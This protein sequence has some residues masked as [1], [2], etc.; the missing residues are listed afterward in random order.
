MG[1]ALLSL[2]SLVAC[3]FCLSTGL[4]FGAGTPK[5]QNLLS[6]EITA[7]DVAAFEASSP[8]SNP[9]KFI[10]ITSY[11]IFTFVCIVCCVLICCLS[12]HSYRH[13]TALTLLLSPIST[14]GLP[15][16][17][18]KVSEGLWRVC[19]AP[20]IRILEKV[21]FSSFDV[22]YCLK[23]DRI[24]SFVKFN[25]KPF[26]LKGHLSASGTFYGINKTDAGI[27]WNKVWTDFEESSTPSAQNEVE[28]VSLALDGYLFVFLCLTDTRIILQTVVH[29]KAC[30]P[31]CLP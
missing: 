15:E 7:V 17:Y 10:S 1:H 16:S 9:G 19:Y 22:F 21:T 29:C 18:K 28:K 13:S 31:A 23:E 11:L 20:H 24:F 3:L 30:L 25:F 12:D 27:Y 4:K 2:L 5:I 26:K 14:T 8:V 6:R